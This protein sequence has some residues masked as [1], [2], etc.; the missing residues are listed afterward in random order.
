MLTIVIVF[1][2]LKKPSLRDFTEKGI[3]EDRKYK[4]KKHANRI[5]SFNIYW[6]SF[7]ITCCTGHSEMKQRILP[8]RR[9]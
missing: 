3:E 2:A 6:C 4:K 9:F 1:L 5:Y 7:Y 8:A